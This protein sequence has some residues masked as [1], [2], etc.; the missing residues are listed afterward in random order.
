MKNEQ[1]W[2][3]QLELEKHPEGGLFASPFEKSDDMVTYK[4]KI[5]NEMLN[6]CCD[7]LLRYIP[8]DKFFPCEKIIR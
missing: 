4:E 1:Y 2:I 5:R 3:E 8:E 6:F 7:E